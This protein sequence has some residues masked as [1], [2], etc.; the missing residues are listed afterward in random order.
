MF[1]DCLSLADSQYLILLL[2]LVLQVS[3]YRT[4]VLFQYGIAVTLLLMAIYP[5]FFDTIPRELF[6]VLFSVLLVL[7]AVQLIYTQ[8]YLYAVVVGVY[9]VIF[10]VATTVLN[11]ALLFTKP[12][13]AAVGVYDLIEKAF[14]FGGKVYRKEIGS[15]DSQSSERLQ[16]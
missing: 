3:L 7:Y 5:I 2:L 12:I 11:T 8:N 16:G 4:H 15:S 9:A 14:T 6:S 10:F 13:D 1:S